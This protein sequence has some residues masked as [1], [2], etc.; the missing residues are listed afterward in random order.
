MITTEL[1]PLAPREVKEPAWLLPGLLPRGELVLLEGAAG[2]G[3]S[4]LAAALAA[5]VSRDADTACTLLT[6]MPG[7]ADVLAAHL[8]RQQPAY[9]KLRELVWY[10]DRD[11]GKDFAAEEA[12]TKLQNHLEEHRPPLLVIDSLEEALGIL[13]GE[14][15]RIM[16]TFWSQLATLA[17]HHGVTILVLTRPQGRR[18]AARVA[19]AAAEAAKAVFTLA[20]HPT[21]AA[22]RV[23][24]RT[25]DLLAPAGAQWHV[26]I[27]AAGRADVAEAAPADHVPPAGAPAT[28]KTERRRDNLAAAVRAIEDALTVM[29]PAPVLRDQVLRQGI[30]YHAFRTAMTLVDAEHKRVGGAWFYAPGLELK[31]LQELRR[32]R[33]ERRFPPAPPAESPD[34]T[35]LPADPRARLA[36]FQRVGA[37]MDAA[38]AVFITEAGAEAAQA[39]FKTDEPAALRV[40]F[41]EM[42]A[43]AHNALSPLERV[44]LDELDRLLDEQEA[45]NAK[46]EPPC[47]ARAH[48]ANR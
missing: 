31:I 42:V 4:L 5:R 8:A 1:R 11:G 45:Q 25:R 16:R 24:T 46:E 44:A 17:R 14:K 18:G 32:Q 43:Q 28:W 21:D 47:C 22:L 40:R 33:A 15:E 23:L 19:R 6:A 27:D 35:T 20:W 3:K 7:S 48:P 26:T 13:A 36:L 10:A 39:F 12:L 2:V 38:K 37:K 9:E 41:E 29:T 30:S 34:A